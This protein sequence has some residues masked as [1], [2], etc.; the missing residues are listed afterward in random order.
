MSDSE[1]QAGAIYL[2]RD[3]RWYRDDWLE[4]P[5]TT[6]RRWKAVCTLEAEHLPPS[7]QAQTIAQRRIRQLYDWQA[8]VVTALSPFQIGWGLKYAR[9][10][11]DADTPA[12]FNKRETP[13][14]RM[15]RTGGTF[16]E[17]R[18]PWGGLPFYRDAESLFKYLRLA[19]LY[20]GLSAVQ[21]DALL[22]DGLN[23]AALPPALQ[24]QALYVLPKLQMWI[25]QH[26]DAPVKLRLPL[27]LPP[28]TIPRSAVMGRLEFVAPPDSP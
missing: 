12:D 18:V 7:E 4:V 11:P 24:S 8:D 26:P 13:I 15:E 6:L 22:A 23:F 3:N 5:A 25:K 9:Y 10:E 20:A 2:V 14:E 17:Y 28:G 27:K 19:Q 21:R 1:K 16:L